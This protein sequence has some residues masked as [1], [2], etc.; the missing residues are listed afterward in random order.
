MRKF[1]FLETQTVIRISMAAAMVAGATL[2]NLNAV[3]ANAAEDLTG[4]Q[5]HLDKTAFHQVHAFGN[6]IGIGLAQGQ[7][8][9]HVSDSGGSGVHS[10]WNRL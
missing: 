3:Y 6:G 10:V 8:Q 2:L 4:A 7:G 5:G 9:K 1:G